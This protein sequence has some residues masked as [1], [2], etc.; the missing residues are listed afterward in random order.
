MVDRE[1]KSVAQMFKRK[2]P[3]DVEEIFA[4]RRLTVAESKRKNYCKTLNI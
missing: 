1:K 4:I 3:K 2:I